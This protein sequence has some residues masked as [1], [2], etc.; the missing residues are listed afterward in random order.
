MSKGL[1]VSL[2]VAVLILAS[3]ALALGLELRTAQVERQSAIENSDHWKRIASKAYT[4]YLLATSPVA[5]DGVVHQM[6][7]PEGAKRE[8]GM[9][10][11]PDDFCAK[12]I[13]RCNQPE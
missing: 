8:G 13:L 2:V 6:L 4:G 11:P 1:Y 3:L 5:Q 7:I 10:L 12:G 9:I